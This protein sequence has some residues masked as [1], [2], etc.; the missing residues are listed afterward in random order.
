[1]AEKHTAGPTGKNR[2]SGRQV[3]PDREEKA[4]PDPLAPTPDQPG[5]A[6]PGDGGQV[7]TLHVPGGP[8]KDQPPANTAQARE[9]G[10][11]MPA[12]PDL[13]RVSEEE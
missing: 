3:S 11:K 12:D 2:A 13:E 6:Q 7:Q 5:Y 10:V 4:A 9:M 8:L 1:M